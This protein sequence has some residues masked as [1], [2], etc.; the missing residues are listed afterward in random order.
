MKKL[1]H[2]VSSRFK[3]K[4]G[5]SDKATVPRITND[6]LAEH[7]EAVIAKGKR[8]KYPMQQTKNRTVLISS[9]IA[10][11]LLALLTF[12]TWWQLYKSQNTS[13]FMYRITQVIPLAVANIDGETVLYKEYLLELRSALHYLTAKE[14]VNLSSDDGRRQLS[15]QKRQAMDKVLEQAY[16]KKLARENNVT[17]SSAEVDAYVDR[18][19]KSNTIGATEEDFKGVIKEYYDWS[20]EDYRQSIRNQL[21][22]RK[23]IAAVD[24]PAKAKAES[25]IRQANRGANFAKLARQ[26]SADEAT[27]Q[28]GGDV[29]FISITGDDPDGLLAEAKNMKKNQVSGPVAGT[30]GYYVIKLIDKRENEVR[31]A[32]IF[33]QFSVFTTQ[34]SEL[35]KQDKIK[36]FIEISEVGS[37]GAS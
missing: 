7:R 19:I 13:Q 15:Y 10:V 36:E 12:F 34:F 6:T 16:V 23:V 33:I 25:V 5:S 1:A 14:N 28:N 11:A 27:R 24:T 37:A 31:F 21:L 17:V 29:G 30:N 18:Q 3:R 20:F 35:R 22:K 4:R 26:N 2:K 9:L 8:Y 32:R